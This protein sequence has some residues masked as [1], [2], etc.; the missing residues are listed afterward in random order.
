MAAARLMRLSASRCTGAL[1][2]ANWPV[3]QG[4]VCV[5]QAGWPLVVVLS[6]RRRARAGDWQSNV[7]HQRATG[8]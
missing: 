6:C 4:G 7:E 8:R 2:R 1:S 5:T 3:S